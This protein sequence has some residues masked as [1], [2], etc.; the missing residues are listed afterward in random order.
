MRNRD[1]SQQEFF[2]DIPAEFGSIFAFTQDVRTTELG[3]SQTLFTWGQVGAAIRAAKHGLATA[4]DQLRQFRQAVQRDVTTAF[5]DV[6]LAR[7][8]AGIAR[9]EPRAAR[10]AARRGRAEAS[11][12]GPPPTTTCWRPGWRS[13]TPGPT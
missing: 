3:L 4:E 8:L 10:A 1:E 11:R 9:A 13:T 6:L 2:S 5:Y 7:E 12:S